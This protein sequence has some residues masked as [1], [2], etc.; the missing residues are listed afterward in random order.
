MAGHNYFVDTATIL[1]LLQSFKSFFE[2]VF[3]SFVWV[4][5]RKKKNIYPDLTL[6]KKPDLEYKTGSE[7]QEKSGSDPRKTSGS[8]RIL[9]L[10]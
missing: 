9:S 1:T 8:R 10:N 2:L 3:F 6:E 4:W 7:H 5:L